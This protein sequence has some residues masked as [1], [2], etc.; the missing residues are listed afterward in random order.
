M[1]STG[2]PSPG[3]ASLPRE[4]RSAV[5]R[6]IAPVGAAVLLY[7]TLW[8]GVEQR[9]LPA[10][11]VGACTLPALAAVWFS[12]GRQRR[13]PLAG[14]L[15]CMACSAGC[16]LA[17]GLEGNTAL[18]WSYMVLMA[19]FFL[20]RNAMA[21]LA[22]LLLVAGLL[23]LPGVLRG[24]PPQW[25]ALA[26]MLL[27]LGIG[28]HF[29]RRLQGD[30]SRLEKL[31]SLDELTGL[32]NRRALERA[33][34][35]HVGGARG[36]RHRYGLVILDIDHFKEVNDRHGHSAG[37]AAL[38][39][40]AAILRR[41]LRDR[42]Q[43]FRFGGEEFVILAEAGSHDAL[44]AFSE[45]IRAAV[46]QSLHG[47]GGGITISLG[48][49]LHAGEQRWQEWFARADAALYQAKDNGRNS[50]VIADAPV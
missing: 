47:P 29:S 32:P 50:A 35:R 44:A 43:V 9:W 40:L 1:K 33:L 39:R 23:V 34:A 46:Q 10:L 11:A 7:Y 16:L 38:S 25:Q 18:A 15:L 27:I 31:A 19:N 26:V 49:A 4:L 36:E 37:D 12:R 20:V 30:R 42:D 24:P 8:L 2:N 5:S 17:A 13:M 3:S 41:E 14:L 48:A 22:G 28:N 21:M 6:A 45:R